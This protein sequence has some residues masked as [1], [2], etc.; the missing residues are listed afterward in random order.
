MKILGNILLL[1]TAVGFLLLGFLLLT[2]HGGAS[3]KISN[4]IFLILSL[5]V[6]LSF[7][8]K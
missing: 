5:G 8:S 4:Y 2:G 6:I 7:K 3:I 1:V